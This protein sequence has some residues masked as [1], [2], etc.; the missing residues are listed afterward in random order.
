MNKSITDFI[1]DHV[2][3]EPLTPKAVGSMI[4]KYIYMNYTPSKQDRLDQYEQFLFML[5]NSINKGDSQVTQKLLTNIRNWELAKTQPNIEADEAEQTA[6][7]NETFY[8]LCK[9]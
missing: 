8:N 2:N 9:I 6:L 3:D 7:E 5:A 1:E 4:R